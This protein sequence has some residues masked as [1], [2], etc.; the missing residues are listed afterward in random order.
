MFQQLLRRLR[1]RNKTSAWASGGPVGG[2]R[3]AEEE[4]LSRFAAEQRK[5]NQLYLYSGKLTLAALYLR[6]VQVVGRT[7]AA[8]LTHVSTVVTPPAP[9]AQNLGVGFRRPCRGQT[10]GGVLEAMAL[11]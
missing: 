7:F 11:F 6:R 10:C 8:A 2:R 9:A 4:K 5:Y 1:L 3:L